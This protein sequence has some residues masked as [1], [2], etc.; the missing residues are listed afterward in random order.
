MIPFPLSPPPESQPS[1]PKSSHPTS[2]DE[3]STYPCLQIIQLNCFNK[4]DTTQELLNLET[5]DVLLLQEPW[6]NPFTHKVLTHPAWHDVTPYDYVPTELTNKFRTCIYIAKRHSIQNISILP[7]GTAFI[8]AVDIVTGD[9]V[10][11]RLRVMSFYNRPST[12]EGSTLLKIWLDQHLSRSVPMLI[13]M[14]ANLHHTQ[15]NPSARSNVHPA[16][17]DLICM[18]GTAG[19]KVISEKGVPTF[20]PRRNGSPSTI[21]L[22]WG[23]WA[24]TRYKL[25][26]TTLTTTFGSDHQALQI[27]IPRTLAHKYVTRNT[28]NLKNLGQATYQE[29]AENQ[30]SNINSNF[31]SEEQ[32]VLGIEQ[33]TTPLTDA[34]FAQGK[35]VKDNI[36]RRKAW[37]NDEKL[38]PLIKTR[39][40]ARRWMIRSQLPEA[41]SCY[42]EWQKFVKQ[43]IETLKRKH[44][45]KFLATSDKNLTFKALFYTLPATTGAVAPLYREDRSIAT[46]KEEQEELLF[47]ATSVALT[48]CNLTDIR[49]EPIPPRGSFP[50]VPPHE[51]ETI[52]SKLPSKKAKG[53]DNVLNE[54]IK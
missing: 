43:E 51:V 2:T 42:W 6:I 44:W 34:F 21:D 12:N 22:T 40:R 50:T 13:G 26:C 25:Q 3:P 11:P 4:Q 41:E 9:A 31:E 19:F 8:T 5:T 46:D 36:H 24:L 10:M 16:A 38:R 27:Q 30:L 37:W 15:W 48:D 33:I 32:A 53:P 39:N 7:S 14:D 52:I 49:Q 17:R 54:L 45:R 47:F 28:A 18:Y 20:Y 23:N 35:V 1:T 29:T